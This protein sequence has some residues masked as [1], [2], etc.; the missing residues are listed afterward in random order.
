MD[1]AGAED[2][3]AADRSERTMS[4]ARRLEK[5]VALVTGAGAGIGAA[6]ATRFAQEGAA[7]ALFDVDEPSAKAA[8]AAIERAGGRALALKGDVARETDVRR[9]IDATVARFGALHVLVNNAGVN[10]MT[11]V[12]RATEEEF[13]RCLD[14][15]LKGVW[16]CSKLALPHLRAAGGGSVVNIASTHAF[17][18]L[19]GSFPYSA[20][21]GGVLALTKSLA[22]D[23]GKD[24]I[25]VNAICPGTIETKM[26]RD[27]FASQPD[28]EAVRRRF[29]A[30]IPLG[31]I[32]TPDDVAALALF[33]AS[34]ESGFL[35]GTT[36]ALD[37]GRDALS[38][39]GV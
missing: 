7:V 33:L 18:T 13:A 10:V 34:D 5:R 37:G 29:L 14:V 11:S 4:A 12:E 15:D 24:R 1:R 38:A 35:S 8:A 23:A 36:I 26:L 2:G 31:R 32:G 30:A 39:A 9:A 25:R 20:A 22:L 3:G 17:R 16:L 19:P 27:W 21:K 28:P 6:I